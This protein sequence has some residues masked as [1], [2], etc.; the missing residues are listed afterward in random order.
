MSSY[1]YK[2]VT[3]AETTY[4]YESLE[5]LI[6]DALSIGNASAVEEYEVFSLNTGRRIYTLVRIKNGVVTLK[7]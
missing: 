5:D 2:I 6:S 3:P 7:L 4:F 1:Q